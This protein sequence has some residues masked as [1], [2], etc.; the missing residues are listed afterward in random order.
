MPNIVTKKIKIQNTKS[1]K[2]SIDSLKLSLYLFL[3]K[4]NSWDTIDTPPIPKDTLENDALIWDEC[5]GGKRIIPTDVNF[6]VKRV[7]W[8]FNTIYD[9]Y[10]NL[11]TNLLNKNFYVMNKEYEVYKCISNNNNSPSLIEPVGKNL[12]IITT[13]DGYRWKYLYTIAP[14]QQ[15]KFLTKNWM[16]VLINS[17]VKAAAKDGGIEHLVLNNG[18]IN[19]S[20]F[21]KVNIIGDGNRANIIAQTRV[22]TI[23]DFIYENP[24][25]GY[26][27]AEVQFSDRSGRFANARPIISPPGGHGFDPITELGAHYLMFNAKT[28]YDEGNGD[29]PADIK[30]RRIFIVA[31]PKDYRNNVANS[32]TLNAMTTLEFNRATGVFQQNEFIRGLSSN[33]NAY[34]V[35]SNVTQGNGII[36]YIQTKN[37]TNNF[38]SFTVGESIIGTTTGT[39]G[40]VSNVILPEVKQDTGDI[41]YIENISP[42]TRSADQAENLHLVIEF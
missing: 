3:G 30:F 34:V 29:I 40:F 6:V 23:Y 19:Y 7:N 22:G 41:I 36:K 42:I 26:R 31:N 28:E 18:G 2:E 10:D 8:E 4:P 24:G 37:L 27:Y 11:D 13:G 5:V 14:A 16:P 32:L 38:T 20:A 33:A 12:N 17:E 15:L 21:T 39:I 35:T 25:E 9:M 1:F